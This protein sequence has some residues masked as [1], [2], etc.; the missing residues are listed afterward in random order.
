MK[1]DL[2]MNPATMRAMYVQKPAHVFELERF[3]LAAK[4][5]DAIQRDV[6][7][8]CR[9]H[10][11]DEAHQKLIEL[12]WYLDRSELCLALAS[13][14]SKTDKLSSSICKTLSVTRLDQYFRHHALWAYGRMDGGEREGVEE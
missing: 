13:S 2:P 4:N 10:E 9:T 7:S 8:F 12:A 3:L 1:G 5:A 6:A 11:L 14:S